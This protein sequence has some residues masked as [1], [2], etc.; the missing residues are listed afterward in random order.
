[1]NAE[2]QPLWLS[3]LK[4]KYFPSSSLMF[5][6]SR[7]GSQFWKSLVKVRPVFQSFVKLLLGMALRLGFGLIGGVEIHLPRLP[8]L[9]FSLTALTL[10][11]LLRSLHPRGGTWPFAVLCRL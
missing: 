7:G 1:M 4:A 8:S 9:P 11:F 10:I 5:A 2:D 3:I 6:Q